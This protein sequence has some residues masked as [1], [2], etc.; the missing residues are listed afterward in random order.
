MSNVEQTMQVGFNDSKTS[1]LAAFA[2]I[3]SVPPTKT[4][5]SSISDEDW[6]DESVGDWCITSGAPNAE[7]FDDLDDID[8]AE[9]SAA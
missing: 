9:I 5:V 2:R 1:I 6:N 4:L 3:E 7:T 8:K